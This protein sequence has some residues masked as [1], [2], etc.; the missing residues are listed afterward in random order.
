MKI[1]AIEYV[2][3][4]IAVFTGVLSLI[5]VASLSTWE[6]YCTAS[7]LAIAAGSKCA[8]YM[9]DKVEISGV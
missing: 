8:L 1:T 3:L 2:M 7:I 9:N 4:A 5:G 6:I